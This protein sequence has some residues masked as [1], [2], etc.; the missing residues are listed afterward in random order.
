MFFPLFTL[1]FV[2]TLSVAFSAGPRQALWM[3]WLPVMLLA[4]VWLVA[5][6]GSVVLD[7]RTAAS[8][9]AILGFLLNSSRSKRT[10]WSYADA[11]IIGVVV[12]QLVSQYQTGNL[13]PMTPLEIGRKWLLPYIM[14]RWFLGT[15]DDLAA[16][17]PYIGRV[18]I[19]LTVLAVFECVSKINPLN[20]IL[21]KTY[22]LLEQGEGYRWGLKRAHVMFDH[23]IFFGMALV[24]MLPWALEAMSQ[25][26]AGKGPHWWRF[27]PVAMAASLFATVS[28]GPQIASIATMGVYFFF[29]LKSLR[30]PLFVVA[31]IVGLIGYTQRHEI[32][33]LLSQF[34]GE[35]NVEEIRYIEIEG[36]EVEYSGTTH[37]VL[38]FRVYA[39]A[40][41]NAGLFGYG[42][43]LKGVSIDESLAQRFGSIDCHY[44]LFLLQNGYLGCGAFIILTLGI[45]LNLARLA[46]RTEYS[47]SALA[48]GL[49][50]SLAGVAVLLISVW[51]SPDFAGVWLFSAGLAASL[52]S[53]IPSEA[54]RETETIAG[55]LPATDTPRPTD[56]LRPAHAPIRN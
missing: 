37:R 21:G 5:G 38:L 32:I 49:C 52:P 14:G 39:E 7:F 18:L 19:V 3:C 13:R 1:I 4:P 12:V 56:P 25:S 11:L 40:I 29:R 34:A 50:G 48:G 41:R 51:F 15:A 53:L 47:Q 20:T 33:D 26:F 6:V 16:A 2:V 46:W 28:R 42:Y 43:E 31:V 17:L 36:E 23:P 8:M 27:L 55:S 35:K 10:G 44:L 24:L 22:A 45:I 30:L 9:A 54:T